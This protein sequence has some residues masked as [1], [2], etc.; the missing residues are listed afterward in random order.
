[1]LKQRSFGVE[2]FDDGFDHQPGRAGRGQRAQR[3]DASQRLRG[4]LGR[5]F[6]LAHERV[7]AGGELELGGCRRAL[8]RVVQH[9][10]VAGLCRHLGD[11]GA[12][13]AGADHEHWCLVQR[14]ECHS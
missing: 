8:A 9:H 5:E 3:L 1:M 7:K 12:H 4:G 2:L 6:A 11:A 14:F 13:D 10:G